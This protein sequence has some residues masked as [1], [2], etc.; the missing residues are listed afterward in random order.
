MGQALAGKSPTFET[1]ET[2]EDDTAVILYTSGTTGSP[3]A[4]SCA[5]AT[6][7]TTSCTSNRLFGSRPGDPDTTLCACRSSTPSVQTV[8][9]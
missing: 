8:H 3:R 9:P 5:T 6:C 1:V 4:P 2:D 7:A